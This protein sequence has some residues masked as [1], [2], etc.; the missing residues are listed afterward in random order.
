MKSE[1]VQPLLLCA[2]GLY[3]IE[4]E[5]R[6]IVWVNDY[7]QNG[8][9]KTL[10]GSYCW[11]AF[12]KR[13]TPCPFC[14][15][16]QENN[17]V[18][19]WEYF[20]PDAKRWMKVKHLLFES[21]GVLYRAGNINMM[22]DVMS[23]NYETVQEILALR[24]TLDKDKVTINAL[25]QEAI[26]DSLT[27]LYNRNCFNNDIKTLYAH[28]KSLGV[29][30]LDMNNLKQIND[31]YRH[32]TG[33]EL[34][35]RLADALRAVAQNAKSAKC[36]RIGGD[37]FALIARNG[38]KTDLLGYKKTFMQILASYNKGKANVCSVAI[39]LAFSPK[40]C[41]LES[42]VSLADSDMYTEKIRM[43]AQ[44][45]KHDNT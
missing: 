41:D 17:K 35:C 21:N 34:L 8:L 45:K 22:D 43:K 3:V 26:F 1:F 31:L 28:D 12:L 27:G 30:F 2:E 20:E 10:I 6:R 29:L 23:L 40:N 19:P 7:I 5:T 39:G 15:V 24:N 37:E 36:Y 32:E 33:D 42:L 14:P 13:D 11:Q 9:N 4:E 16:L 25:T 38:T 44:E 18:Y